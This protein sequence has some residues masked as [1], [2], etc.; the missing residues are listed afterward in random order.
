MVCGLRADSLASAPCATSRLSKLEATAGNQNFIG[1]A[2]DA[3][4]QSGDAQ[5]ALWVLQETA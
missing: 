5:R 1:A 2:Q 4:N 3:V